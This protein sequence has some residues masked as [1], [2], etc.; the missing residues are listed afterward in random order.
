MNYQTFPRSWVSSINSEAPKPLSVNFGIAAF[1][2]VSRS[3]KQ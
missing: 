3:A 2:R 1:K